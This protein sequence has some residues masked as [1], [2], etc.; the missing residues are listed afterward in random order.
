[1]TEKKWLYRKRSEAPKV[2]CPCGESTRVVTL[3][4]TPVANLHVTHI[5]DS[6]KHYHKECTEYYYVLEGQGK[7]ELDDDV[8]DLEPGVTVVIPPGIAHRAYGDVTLIV[9]GVPACRHDDE[10]FVQ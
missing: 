7:L 5:T 2:P 3:A 10:F 8:V 6:V 4:D 9:F 1:M